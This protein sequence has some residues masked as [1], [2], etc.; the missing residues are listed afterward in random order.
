MA[1]GNSYT[2]WREYYQKAYSAFGP[3][4]DPNY[5]GWAWLTPGLDMLATISASKGWKIPA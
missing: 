4:S 1:T 2:E 3:F 5:P